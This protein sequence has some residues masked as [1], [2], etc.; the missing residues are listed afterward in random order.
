MK[1]DADAKGTGRDKP[2]C[3]LA[4]PQNKARPLLKGPQG[5]TNSDGNTC[6]RPC[7]MNGRKNKFYSHQ[8][9]A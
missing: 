8:D 9:L 7:A 1:P 6:R 4:G 5:M 2:S 3:S